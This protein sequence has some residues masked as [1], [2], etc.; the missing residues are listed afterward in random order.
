MLVTA[1]KT[2]TS[3]TLDALRSRLGRDIPGGTTE[4]GPLPHGGL[5]SMARA[6]F[7]HYDDQAVERLARRLAA[8]SAGIPLLAVEI[9]HAIVSGLD[10]ERE[11]GSWPAPYH[12]LTHTTPGDLPDTVVS[13]IRIGF[14]RLS[15]DAQQ[16]LAAA[17][18][19][20]GRVTAPR[21]AKVTGLTRPQVHSAAD[22][23]EWQRWLVADG[24]GYV[25]VARIVERIIERDMLTPGQRRRIQDTDRPPTDT[26][27]PP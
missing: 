10:L 25:F 14:R 20:G 6:V 23:L 8:D 16:V 11:S 27:G 13:A 9:L 5:A 24:R 21:L 3:A 19:L 17:A 7:P 15:P 12:T 26:E 1:E 18:A 2:A 22:E 4:L